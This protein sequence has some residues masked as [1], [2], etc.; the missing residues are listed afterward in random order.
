[1]GIIGLKSVYSLVEF[2]LCLFGGKF[3]IIFLNYSGYF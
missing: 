3:N 1:M 2:R